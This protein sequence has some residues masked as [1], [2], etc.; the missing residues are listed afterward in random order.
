VPSLCALV[1]GRIPRNISGCF[2]RICTRICNRLPSNI[3][4]E[5]NF[6]G[7]DGSIK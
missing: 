5:F 3:I 7:M 4:H 1:E 6:D 2:V